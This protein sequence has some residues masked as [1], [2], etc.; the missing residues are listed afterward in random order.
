MCLKNS[1]PLRYIPGSSRN[2]GPDLALSH[3]A[4]VAWKGKN[5]PFRSTDGLILL[6]QHA[7][8]RGHGGRAAMSA[9]QMRRTNP[10]S[11]VLHGI[12]EIIGVAG[13]GVRAKWSYTVSLSLCGLRLDASM[14]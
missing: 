6:A 13:G 5:R 11:L 4:P 9:A 1:C 10:I 7:K 8:C 12:Q 3:D 14:A 2:W